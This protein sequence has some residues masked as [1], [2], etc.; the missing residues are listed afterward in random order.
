MKDNLD[1]LWN[2]HMKFW[3]DWYL[4][5]TYYM[6]K[7]VDR[8]MERKRLEREKLKKKEKKEKRKGNK[9]DHS[10]AE[11]KVTTGRSKLAQT[12]AGLKKQGTLV[13]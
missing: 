6:R 2:M 3:N 1:F 12:T 7:F 5:V 11:R 10:K 9:E 8:I 13:G 4:F